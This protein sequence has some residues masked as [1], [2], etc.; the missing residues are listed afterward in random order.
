MPLPT[1]K[2]ILFLS[3]LLFF[4]TLFADTGIYTYS[5]SGNIFFYSKKGNRVLQLTHS[6]KSKHAVLSP[7]GR[8]VVYVKKSNF[9]A[10]RNCFYFYLRGEHADE[11]WIADLSNMEKRLLVFP[12]FDCDDVSKDTMDPHHLIF[13]PNGKTIYF[14]TSAWVTSGAV[15]A[16]DVDG[17]NSRFVIDGTELRI[18][19]TGRYK[20]DL[21]V[22]QHRYHDKGGSYNWDWLFTP[23]G[24]QIKLYK[25]E[26]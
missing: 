25:K 7:N 21:I 17:K 4:E 23:E 5:K 26:I 24:K 3:F 22:N 11:I 10:P 20:G 16:V 13:S 2:M 18:V 15:H 9:V 8:Y 19:Q 14:E 12:T 1:K 6:G